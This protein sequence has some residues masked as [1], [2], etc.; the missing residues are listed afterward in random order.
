MDQMCIY[1]R[2]SHDAV[3]IEPLVCQ[4]NKHPKGYTDVG[5]FVVIFSLSYFVIALLLLYVT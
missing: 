4:G 2:V 3:Q 1:C 5:G